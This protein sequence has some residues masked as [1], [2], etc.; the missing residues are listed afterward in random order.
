MAVRGASRPGHETDD[1]L[2]PVLHEEID[3]LPESQRLPVVLCD[4]EGLTY[5]QAAD[6]LRW[7]V[8]A[9]RCRLAK[10]RQ[11]LKGRLARRGFAGAAVGAVLAAN[12]ARA[13]VPPVLLRSTVLASTGGSASAG[14]V[15]L[16]QVLLR[17]MLMTKINFVT[18]AAVAAL[19]LASAGVIAAGGRQPDDAKPAVK[20]QAVRASVDRDKPAPEKPLETV[21]IRA[22]VVDLE[23]RPVAGASV[24]AER[25]WY[26]AT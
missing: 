26:D 19:A 24:R 3:R 7:T 2:R 9:V 10:A 16:T 25:I 6:Q 1:D 11:R 15:L 23:G 5:N 18:T 12:D 22:R 4:L 20:P 14:V 13:A 8:P 17:E 21:E